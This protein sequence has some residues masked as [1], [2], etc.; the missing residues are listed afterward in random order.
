MDEELDILAIEL[1]HAE[2]MTDFKFEL[3]L[4]GAARIPQKPVEGVNDRQ[5]GSDIASTWRS[6]L[7]DER[8][9]GR[10]FSSGVVAG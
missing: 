4:R 6:K 1:V 8:R 3:Q 5:L 10:G 7:P 2:S 9:C